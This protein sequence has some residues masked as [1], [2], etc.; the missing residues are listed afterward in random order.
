MRITFYFDGN[1][2]RL[3][4]E[5]N[6]LGDNGEPI[7]LSVTSKNVL[8]DGM[9]LF[10]SDDTAGDGSRPAAKQLQVDTHNRSPNEEHNR[11]TIDPRM[12]GMYPR[13]LQSLSSIRYDSLLTRPDRENV[14]IEE[15]FGR[16]KVAYA[17]KTGALVHSF[18]FGST[19]NRVTA[20]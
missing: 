4:R 19:R 10:H 14:T 16:T 15:E 13:G 7:G 5:R 12:I 11:M 8:A 18:G 2:V 3:D 1:K 9:Y 20:W 17:L 6:V